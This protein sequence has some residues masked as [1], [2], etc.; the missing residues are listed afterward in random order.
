MM[1]YGEMISMTLPRFQTVCSTRIP[2]SFG[3]K[4]IRTF[5]SIHDID[6]GP[7]FLRGRLVFDLRRAA[8][9]GADRGVGGRNR[10]RL[11]FRHFHAARLRDLAIDLRL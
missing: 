11:R 10:G 9:R 7:G 6:T 3:V 5:Y 4:T 2:T 8:D 1:A